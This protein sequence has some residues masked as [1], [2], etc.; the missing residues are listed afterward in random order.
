MA[1]KQLSPG[2]W[3]AEIQKCS[4]LWAEMGKSEKAVYDAEAAA[5]QA[6]RENAAH[7]PFPAKRMMQEFESNAAESSAAQQLCRNARST[8]AKQRL[9]TTYSRFK[10]A[11]EWAEVDSG[12]ASAEGAVK[13]DCIDLTSTDT[14]IRQQWDSF[15]A[16]HDN[17]NLCSLETGPQPHHS[18]CYQNH[19]GLCQ[20]SPGL[21][22]A[23]KFVRN[24]HDLL[25]SGNLVLNQKV[26]YILQSLRTVLAMLYSCCL[27]V[28]RHA[29]F[30]GR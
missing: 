21:D 18:T 2:E 24:M 12:L 14:D 27:L 4:N 6:I 9:L 26:L 13:L 3:K 8:I 28:S 1:G 5:E 29:G 19:G 7:E 16:I 30:F 11:P 15:A 23:T 25:N 22:L 20:L 17:S 10:E